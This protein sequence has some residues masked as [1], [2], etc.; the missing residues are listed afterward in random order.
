MNRAAQRRGR[1]RWSEHPSWNRPRELVSPDLRPR[2]VYERFKGAGAGRRRNDSHSMGR[3]RRASD[4]PAERPL[5]GATSKIRSFFFG[6]EVDEG[7]AE[8]LR[9]IKGI[10]LVAFAL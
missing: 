10:A 1:R 6:R 2:G 7:T 4:E 3:K 8:R 9:E 5:G